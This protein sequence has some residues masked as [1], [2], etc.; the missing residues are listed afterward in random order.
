MFGPANFLLILASRGTEMD[1]RAV[2]IHRKQRETGIV[3]A[4]VELQTRYVNGR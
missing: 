2:S 4:V 1:R 3:N